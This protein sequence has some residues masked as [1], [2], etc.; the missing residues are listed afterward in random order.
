MYSWIEEKYV[1]LLSSQLRNF[2]RKKA[3]LWNCSCPLC[4]DSVSNKR[5]AR[6][7]IYQHKGQLKFKCHNC[8]IAM[9]FDTFL[10]QQNP[11]LHADLLK[12]LY[13]NEANNQPEVIDYPDEVVEADLSIFSCLKSLAD[14]SPTHPAR[15]YATGRM[16]PG[17]MF[18]HLFYA[19][20]FKKFTNRIV[21][22]KFD[23]ES[24]TR[25]E[26]RLII[27][28]VTK[29]KKVIAFTG[30][31]FDPN[32]KVRYLQIALDRD[33]PKIFGADRADLTKKHFIVEGPMDAMFL[34]NTVAA[35][36]SSIYQILNDNSVAVFDNEPRNPE[37]CKLMNR[38]I[39]KGHKICIWPPIVEV[40]D[41]NELVKHGYSTKEIVDLINGNT[42]SGLTAKAK[43]VE[44]KK[45]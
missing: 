33:A 21:P 3:G 11:T 19:P 2:K 7:Y 42:Y 29:D 16:I 13:T 44:W 8:G 14:L 30:R 20:Y 41:I 38:V 18:K 39:E 35:G 40:K 34:P 23:S 25:D 12:E 6:G 27:P 37:I 15:Q 28:F 24:V 43:F 1:S 10:K 5:K 26:P 9:R 36:G 4:G 17:E 31:S 22:E 32:A 45:T